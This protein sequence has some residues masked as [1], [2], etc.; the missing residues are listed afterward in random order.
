MFTLGNNNVLVSRGGG[1]EVKRKRKRER[2]RLREVNLEP[3]STFT[4]TQARNKRE[5]K[6]I[7][8]FRVGNNNV[9]VRR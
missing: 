5:G 8:L 4:E 9:L 1:E 7:V 3:L 6:S 2:K